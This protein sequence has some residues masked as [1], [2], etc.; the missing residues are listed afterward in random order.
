MT[1]TVDACALTT[2]DNPWDYFDNFDEWYRYDNDKGYGTLN[3]LARVAN[4][5]DDMTESEV[6]R[7]TERAVDSIVLF[8]P[9]NLYKKVKRKVEVDLGDE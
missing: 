4:I 8:D 7:E 9:F 2:V 3:Y 1:I 6:A 5:S